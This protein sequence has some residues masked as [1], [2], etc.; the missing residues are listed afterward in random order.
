MRKQNIL[1]RLGFHKADKEIYMVE[2]R[3]N[4]KHKWHKN[5]FVC[6]RCGKRLKSFRLNRGEVVK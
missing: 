4:G 2:N 5:Y 6:A 3:R 1:C